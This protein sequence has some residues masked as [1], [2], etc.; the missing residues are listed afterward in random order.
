MCSVNCMGGRLRLYSGALAV[1]HPD[2]KFCFP[3][4]DDE[5]GIC[6]SSLSSDVGGEDSSKDMS[7]PLS[8]KISSKICSLSSASMSDHEKGRAGN[9]LN[10]RARAFW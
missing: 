6:S 8:A 2:R 9:Y 7:D 1:R 5:V 10:P 3:D 4:E